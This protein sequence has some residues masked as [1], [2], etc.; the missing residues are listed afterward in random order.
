MSSSSIAN[1]NSLEDDW[2]QDRHYGVIIDAGSSGSRVYVYSWKD[3][4]TAKKL[5]TSKELRGKIPVVERADKEGL[6]WTSRE[7]PG[8]S[9]Y[10]S[11]PNEVG[12]HL[13]MLLEFAQ[14]V[15]P[16]KNHALTPIF[17][18]ATAGMRLLPEEQQKELLSATCKYIRDKTSFVV[19]DCDAHVRIIPGELEGVYGWVAINYL[20]GGFDNSI[21]A[22]AVDKSEV[23]EQQNNDNNDKKLEQHHTFGFLDMGGASAQIAF[24]PEHHQKEEHIED[25]TRITLHTLDGR[26]VDYDVFVTTFLGYGSN[27][28]RRRYLEERVKELY[29]SSNGKKNLLDEHRMLKL[30][31]PCLPYNLDMTDISSTSVSLSLHG[32]GDYEKCIEYTL[33]LL[34]KNAECPSKPCLFNGVH[35]PH[36]DWSVHKFVGIS[37]YWYSAHDIL[38]LGGVYDFVE[39]EKKASNYCAKDWSTSDIDGK[40][41]LTPAEL[42]RY[43][44]QC[45]KSA[46]I[47]NVLHEGIEIPRIKNPSGH[48]NL[49]EDK[50]ILEQTIESVDAKNWNPPFQSIDTIN[51]IQVSWTL[52]AMLLHVASQIPLVDYNDGFLGHSTDDEGP[53]EIADGVAV[54]P[55]I[56]SH[57]G[58]DII[59]TNTS[60]SH[61]IDDDHAISSKSSTANVLMILLALIIVLWLLFRFIRKN[62]YSRSA[63][64]NGGILGNDNMVA[65][66]TCSYYIN[67]MAYLSSL[68]RFLSRSTVAMR[69]SLSSF[70]SRNINQYTSVN[71]SIPV[72]LHTFEEGVGTVSIANNSNNNDGIVSINIGSPN[73]DDRVL[74]PS[75]KSPKLISKQYWNKKRYSGDSHNTYSHTVDVVEGSSVLPFRTSSSAMGLANRNSGSSTNIAAGGRPGSTPNL[76]ALG[77]TAMERTTSP[78][79]TEVNMTRSRSRIGFVIHE[80]SDEEDYALSDG[81]LTDNPATVWLQ[82][83]QQATSS[84]RVSS[85]RLSPRGSLERRRKEEP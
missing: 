23:K 35:T 31:D 24:E 80:Q 73:N 61:S 55:S 48:H 46:W 54:Y 28:A 68:S 58:E 36:I 2:E 47:V 17:L 52:G 14:E 66:S 30:D 74:G 4:E 45:F 78:L 19:R 13:D 57:Y 22:Y 79:A 33:P 5:F 84:S 15:V 21:K 10:G 7:E 1:H 71:T 27:E 51:D 41:D 40:K 18:M 20:M 76:N 26:T 77:F 81:P 62:S 32:T 49:T 6:K 43:Q 83:Q 9:T 38:G 56:S 34:N 8:I 63:G 59:E 64:A 75:S 67:P 69:S 37:E 72:D 11:R 70:M 16:E 3:H 85:P 65:V 29:A 39:Y 42:N 60:A 50:E 82:Q 53:H 44:M 12:E 25:L